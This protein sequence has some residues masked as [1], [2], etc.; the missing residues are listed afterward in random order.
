V[1][2]RGFLSAING[3]RDWLLTS[4]RRRDFGR[5]GT[6]RAL[7]ATVSLEVRQALVP[8]VERRTMG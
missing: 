5:L 6:D 2:R 4:A 3:E 8:L 1:S 7:P